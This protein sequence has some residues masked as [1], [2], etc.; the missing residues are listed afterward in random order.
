MGKI[1]N[2]TLELIGNTPLLNASRYAENA[3]ITDATILAK[4][5]LFNPAGS[6]KERVAL[7]MIDDAEQKELIKRAR[8][9][10]YYFR[11]QE[12]DICQHQCFANRNGRR[13]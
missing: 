6:A 5:E 8:T 1:I 3:G 13:L 9:L 12:T 10:L 11:I 2:S 7:A 4:L